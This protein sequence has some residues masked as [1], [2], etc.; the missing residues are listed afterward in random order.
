MKSPKPYSIGRIVLYVPQAETTPKSLPETYNGVKECPA[1]IVEDWLAIPEYQET[2]KVNLKVFC[3]GPGEAWRTSV[4]YS[5][6]KEPGTWHWP[7]ITPAKTADSGGQTP[8]PGPG[9]PGQ[10]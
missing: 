6:G 2:G 1:V 10:P 5:E 9:Q 8:P 3:D 4:P 7:D